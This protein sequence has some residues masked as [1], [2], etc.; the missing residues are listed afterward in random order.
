MQTL[1]SKSTNGCLSLEESQRFLGEV[2]NHVDDNEKEIWHYFEELS[3][4]KN[5]DKEERTDNSLISI[6]KSY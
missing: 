3:R 1:V 4:R 2:E 5:I 6:M